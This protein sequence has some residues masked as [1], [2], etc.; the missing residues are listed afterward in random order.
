[1]HR[2]DGQYHAFFIPQTA[3]MPR[4]AW[5]DVVVPV[6]RKRL[7]RTQQDRPSI[8]RP[9][10]R[11]YKSNKSSSSSSHPLRRLTTIFSS[12]LVSATAFNSSLS[13]SSVTFCRSCPDRASMI[14]RFS[15]SV[16]RDSLTRR[17]RPSRSAASG[18]RIWLR[19]DCRAS[20]VEWVGSCQSIG[21]RHRGPLGDVPSCSLGR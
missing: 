3:V 19:I 14:S 1:M 17:M 4:R 10:H 20:A 5:N 6:L 13:C 16:A 15:T 21:A 18:W 11:D 7:V 2:R 12:A 9:A 8:P